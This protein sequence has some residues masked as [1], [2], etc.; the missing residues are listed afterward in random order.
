VGVSSSN[1]HF[2]N[3]CFIRAVVNASCFSPIGSIEVLTSKTKSSIAGW[4]TWGMVGWTQGFISDR[5]TDDIILSI[6]VGGW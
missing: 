6:L 3:V 2:F 1:V 5:L 4:L